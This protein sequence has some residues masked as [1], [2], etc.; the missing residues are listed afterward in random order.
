M[1]RADREL[2]ADLARLNSD[3]VPLAMQ[4]MDDS[5][6]REGQQM[7]A[8]RLI[9]LGIRL[10]HRTHPGIVI[11]GDTGTDEAEETPREL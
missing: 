4:I 6:A 10:N 9:E 1:I 2:L 7:F 3:V 5:A 8:Y 11:D